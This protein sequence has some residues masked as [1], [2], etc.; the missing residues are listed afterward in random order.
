MEQIINHNGHRCRK[1]WILFAALVSQ[2]FSCTGETWVL[3]THHI[4]REEWKPGVIATDEWREVVT[5][6]STEECESKKQ[7]AWNLMNG[8]EAIGPIIGRTLH[9]SITYRIDEV[10][11]SSPVVTSVSFLCLKKSQKP[12]G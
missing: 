11:T 2:L 10:K 6:R 8:R 4:V 7:K 9:E 3:W 5:V 1:E 12:K